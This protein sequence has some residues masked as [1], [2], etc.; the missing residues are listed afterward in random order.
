VTT[1]EAPE[2]NPSRCQDSLL[3]QPLRLNSSLNSSSFL[4]TPTTPAAMAASPY[5]S[6][7]PTHSIPPYTTQQP[8]LI[9]SPPITYPHRIYC[10]LWPL[11]L[12]YCCYS[13]C[14]SLFWSLLSLADR[15]LTLS[16]EPGAGSGRNPHLL[17]DKALPIFSS[18]SSLVEDIGE[19]SPESP[20]LLSCYLCAL[21]KNCCWDAD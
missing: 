21:L 6:Q 3:Y 16:L 5:V 9:P 15:H 4:T 2:R 18:I 20:V 1:R 12:C 10:R 13:G 8:I 7:H 19:E 11:S 17:C 14:C